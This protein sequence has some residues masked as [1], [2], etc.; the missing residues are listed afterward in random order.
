MQIPR[1]RTPLAMATVFT[2]INGTVALGSRYVGHIQTQ[3]LLPAVL[4][5]VPIS[6]VHYLIALGVTNCSIRR[7]MVDFFITGGR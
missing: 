4:T 3:G 6:C 5:A 7:D 2:G 1:L